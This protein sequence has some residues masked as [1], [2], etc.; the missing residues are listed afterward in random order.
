LALLVCTTIVPAQAIKISQIYGGGANQ[1]APLTRDYVELY[2]TT[3]SAVSLAGWS[4]QYAS[5]AGVFT[6]TQTLNLTGTIPANGY[7]LVGFLNNSAATTALNAPGI[8]AVDDSNTTDMAATSGKV[9][10]CNTTT[11]LTS[12]TPTTTGFP[13][14]VDF[15]GFGAIAS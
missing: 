11:V 8:P 12:G 3:S 5:A 14:L 6:T 9:A 13:A 15:V 4:V 10:L 2:N 1:G 7:Y